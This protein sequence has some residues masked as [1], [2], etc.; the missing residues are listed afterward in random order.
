ME[1]SRNEV[2]IIAE[3][4]RLELSDQELT[5]YITDMKNILNLAAQLNEVDTSAIKPMAHPLEQTQ[6][7][8]P[9]LVT[10]IVDRDY[11]QSI[12]PATSEG[13]YLVPKVIEEA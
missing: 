7:L 10:E 12:A 9:D 2:E 1:I 13:Y 4:A 5:E 8:R 3:M 6:V 11:L